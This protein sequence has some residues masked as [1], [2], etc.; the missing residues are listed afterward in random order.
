MTKYA[1]EFDDKNYPTTTDV[2]TDSNFEKD[3]D[4]VSAILAKIGVNKNQSLLVLYEFSD[5][6]TGQE[7]LENILMLHIKGFT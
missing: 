4:V 2:C 7:E 5:D 3:K 6:E 1:I